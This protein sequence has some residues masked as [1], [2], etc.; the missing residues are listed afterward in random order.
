MHSFIHFIYLLLFQRTCNPGGNQSAHTAHSNRIAS[1]PT[2]ATQATQ[3]TQLTLTTQA[4]DG[5]SLQASAKGSDG[6]APV[7][8]LLVVD[9]REKNPLF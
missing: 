2:Q 5:S 6:V 7:V 8:G 3:A 4:R 1:Q 9:F